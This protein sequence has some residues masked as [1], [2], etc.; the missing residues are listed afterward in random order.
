[1][2]IDSSLPGTV[3]ELRPE[4]VA[5]LNVANECAR[6]SVDPDLLELLQVRID[7]L[8]GGGSLPLQKLADSESELTAS[9]NVATAF[10]EQFIIDVSGITDADRESLALY[11]PGE[12]MREFVTSL[13]ILECTFRLSL[14]TQMLFADIKDPSIA[15]AFATNSVI[16]TEHQNIRGSLKDYQDAVVRGTDLDPVTTELV[17]LRCART[18]NCRICQTL[19]LSDA[20]AAGADDTMTAK[21]D[22]YELSDLPEAHKVALRITDALITRPDTLTVE[23]VV[24]AR[25]NYTP[26]QL[27]EMCLDIT[28]WSTQ[29]IHVALGIDG[30]DAV[31]KNEQGVSFFGFDDLG[32]VTGYSA[33][34]TGKDSL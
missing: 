14:V 22:F 28:K 2:P 17:R 3:I 15:V 30:A 6:Q 1:M 32:Q 21:V 34:P 24:A 12:A 20:R 16:P 26:A 18:H 23:T 13:Y 8:I 29:K 9:G 31:P 10:A 33:T 7:T 19:R 25:A 11:F 4:A 27:A 5:L